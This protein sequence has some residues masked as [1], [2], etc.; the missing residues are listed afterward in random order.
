VDDVLVPLNQRT[1]QEGIVW[2]WAKAD[3][4]K[5]RL[6]QHPQHPRV[7]AVI[8][9]PDGAANEVTLVMLRCLNHDDRERLWR[10]RKDRI[11]V[12]GT[13]TTPEE[14]VNWLLSPENGVVSPREWVAEARE[15]AFFAILAKLLKNKDWAN[16]PQN[17]NFTQEA[18]LLGQAPVNV[19]SEVRAEA[20]D[21]LDTM[22]DVI[23]LTKGGSQGTT[24]KKWAIYLPRLGAVMDA[25]LRRSLVPLEKEP[26][27]T[28]LLAYVRNGRGRRFRVDTFVDVERVREVCH[29]KGLGQ[30]N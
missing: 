12:P 21:L 15:A 11:L 8:Y 25:F 29:R 2:E 10:K 9:S 7:K 27:M 26:G 3:P 4:H 5:Y 17:H 19:H 16:G 1:G 6:P 24:K 13:V 30:G 23:L 14:L 18:D 22:K 20:N 28:S